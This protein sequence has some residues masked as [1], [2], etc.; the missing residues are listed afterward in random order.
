MAYGSVAWTCTLIGERRQERGGGRV[1][2][3]ETVEFVTTSF[4]GWIPVT[5]WPI[6]TGICA[7]WLSVRTNAGI[8]RALNV[9][10]NVLA[11]IN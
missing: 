3:G 11:T 5:V 10:L 4:R 7:Y 2:W 6:A 9:E 8:V 1:I